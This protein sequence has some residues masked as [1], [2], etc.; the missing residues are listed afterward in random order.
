MEVIT[1]IKN[2]VSEPIYIHY[3][4]VDP[5]LIFMCYWAIQSIKENVLD[6]RT[7]IYTV[8]CNNFP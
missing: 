7:P 3:S 4:N 8:T 6:F 1:I 5:E 2:L